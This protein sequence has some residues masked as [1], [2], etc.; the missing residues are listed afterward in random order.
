[1]DK[2]EWIIFFAGF[3]LSRLDTPASQE[4]FASW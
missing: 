1:L 4:V 2:I 3:M